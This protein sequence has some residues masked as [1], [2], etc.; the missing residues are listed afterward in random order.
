MVPRS[1]GRAGRARLQKPI[2]VLQ[3]PKES[4]VL[5]GGWMGAIWMKPER[6]NP[7]V[8]YAERVGD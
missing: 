1:E 4:I 6:P 8:P 7:I 2:L 3:E 5:T